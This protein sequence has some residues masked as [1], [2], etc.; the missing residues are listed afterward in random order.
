ML[1]RNYTQEKWGNAQNRITWKSSRE[2]ECALN[3]KH[4]GWQ[5]ENKV[6]MNWQAK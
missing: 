2:W 3:G 1:N 5:T 4:R 6:K